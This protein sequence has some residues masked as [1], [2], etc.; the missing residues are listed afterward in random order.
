MNRP[1]MALAIAGA[2]L[3]ACGG[4][5]VF[6][7]EAAFQI[8]GLCDRPGLLAYV[9]G[10]GVSGI[11]PLT[12][13]ADRTVRGT[14]AV[15]TGEIREFRLTYYTVVDGREVTLA[16]IVASLDLRDVREDRLVLEFDPA[17]LTSD[18]DDDGDGRTNLAEFCEGTNPRI[19]D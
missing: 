3:A 17:A 5:E 8:E 9:Q 11:C 7:V 16:F 18:L 1:W 12:V 4:D 15:P 19:R 13:G 10:T 2:S 6:D 14:C